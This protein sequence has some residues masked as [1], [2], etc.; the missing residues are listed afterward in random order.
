MDVGRHRPGHEEH[1]AQGCHHERHALGPMGVH[2]L[3][4]LQGR[5]DEAGRT[6][7]VVELRGRQGARCQRQCHAFSERHSSPAPPPAGL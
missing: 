3:L 6:Q 2:D 7:T 5:K 1:G 4:E